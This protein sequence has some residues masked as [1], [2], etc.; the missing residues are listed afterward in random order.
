MFKKPCVTSVAIL[1][2]ACSLAFGV[3]AAAA[4]ATAPTTTTL[5]AASVTAVSAN[6]EGTITPGGATITAAS[7]CYGTSSTLSGC[8]SAALSSSVYSGLSSSST[9]DP[10]YVSLTGLSPNTTYYYR[11][12][13]TNSAGTGSSST[14][15]GSFTT[16]AVGAFTCT[17]AFYQ[18]SATGSGA[19]YSFS[20]SSN[21]FTQIGSGSQSGINGVAYDTTDN[22]LY[23]I[24]SNT[25]Y[26]I[27]NDGQF[28]S[29]GSLSTSSNNTGA[30]FYAGALLETPGSGDTFDSVDVSTRVVTPVTMTNH[31]VGGVSAASGGWG[32]SDIT[33]QGHYG[34]GLSTSSSATTLYV[35]D[36][37]ND[38]IGAISVTGIP[39]TGS[40]AYG[41]AYSD[42]NGNAY[43]YNNTTHIMYEIPSSA[44]QAA[45]SSGTVPAG[46]AIGSGATSPALSAPNDGATC[47]NAASPYAPSVTPPTTGAVTTTSAAVSSVVSPSDSALTDVEFCYSSSSATATDGGALT[48]SPTCVAVDQTA[49]PYT[50]WSGTNL[51][52]VAATLSGLSGCSTYYYQSEA[53][54]SDGTAY[55]TPSNF[56]TPGCQ[57]VS[58]TSSAPSSP[59]AGDTY[60][61]TGTATSGL[62]PVVTVDASSS[63]VCTISG[64][65]V[66][67]TAAGT[68]LLDL[69]QAGNS[70]FAA[71]PQV[72]QAVTVGASS[73]PANQ[74]VSFTSTAPGSAYVGDQYTP[75]GSATSGLTPVIT[76]DTS[77]TSIC[78]ISAGVV[79]FNAAGTCVLDID[80]AGNGSWNPATQVQQSITV[81]LATQ[82]VSFS[83]SAPGSAIV[84]DTYTPSGSATSGLTPVITVDSGSSAVCHM[85]GSVVSFDAAGTCVLDIN[86]A[87]NGSWNPAT[88]VQQ[89]I[90]VGGPPASNQTVSFSSSAPSGALAGASYTPAGSATSGL[91]PVITVDSGSSAVCHMSGSVVSFDAAGT[92]VLDINQAGNGS[93]NP[94]TQVQQSIT[95]SSPP[96]TPTTSTPTPTPTPTTPTP[97]P[98]SSTPAPTSPAPTTPTPKPTTNN[99]APKPKVQAPVITSVTPGNGQAVVSWTTP[100]HHDTQITGYVVTTAS[101]KVVCRTSTT[102][103][104]VSG[105]SNGTS[106]KFK[107]T[108]VTANHA[109]SAP[110]VPQAVTTSAAPVAAANGSSATNGAAQVIS[111]GGNVSQVAV[112]KTGSTVKIGDGSFGLALGLASQSVNYSHSSVSMFSGTKAR[113]GGYGFLPGSTVTLYI[114]S[115]HVKLGTAKVGHNGRFV[116]DFTV[117]ATLKNGDHTLI[118]TGITAK[119]KRESVEGSVRV[120]SKTLLVVAPFVFSESTLTP[121]LAQLVQHDAHTIAFGGVR[122]VTISAYT[123]PRG[124]SSYNVALSQRRAASVAAR[125]RS[126]LSA[127]GAASIKVV[128][129]ANGKADP[130]VSGGQ[131][132]NAA[133]RRVVITIS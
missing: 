92:C 83:S 39:N 52:S 61:P 58:F 127:L 114:S 126:D 53:V 38:Y 32:A 81:G 96:P 10:V 60:S 129:L 75:A 5:T 64:G 70:S 41:A 13:A 54:N 35:A 57:S 45:L 31:T 131:V 99:V 12:S 56:T 125:L 6:V 89:S 91:T 27:N 110:S 82:T 55:S 67:F 59:V 74:T 16:Q 21:S 98:T 30:D 20:A 130:V 8:T 48:G 29:K 103:C 118:S 124:S 51:Y 78:S 119:R 132:V 133:S 17:P 25:L 2:C 84:G 40:Y 113:I 50:T 26:Q 108:A 76:V 95:V 47:P 77:A 9:A 15:Y 73:G 88:Q 65:V 123:D 117:P 43:F 94:A 63:S 7:F 90:T 66:T 1:V 106:Y 34:Y 19:L 49:Y 100:A 80:Q 121:A 79:S 4:S 128:V 72:Q 116:G 112:S 46:Q 36:L 33:I 44:L 115:S 111:A 87:G 86:Q 122:H 93:W 97:A 68:C 102:T 28:T 24:A 3:G 37:N 62:T 109:T 120:M 85:S 107:V 71:A 18:V 23:G 11:L 104:L 14:P 101:G 22:Y 69:N 105:L 42:P